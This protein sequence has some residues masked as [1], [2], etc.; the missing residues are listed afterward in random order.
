MNE[1]K[2][3]PP[4]LDPWNGFVSDSQRTQHYC[5]LIEYDALKLKN[6]KDWSVEDKNEFLTD[7][8]H[9]SR[10]IWDLVPEESGTLTNAGTKNEK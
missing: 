9:H 10:L 8:I 6:E 5:A 3:E 7:I 1:Y 4:K 2:K